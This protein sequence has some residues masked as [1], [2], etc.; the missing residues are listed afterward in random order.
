LGRDVVFLSLIGRTESLIRRVAYQR[1][2]EGARG[3]QGAM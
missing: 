3:G 2:S 1:A